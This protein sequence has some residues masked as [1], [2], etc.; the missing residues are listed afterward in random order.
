MESTWQGQPAS[1]VAS[2]PRPDIGPLRSHSHG[3]GARGPL[4]RW[5]GA[6]PA[7][8]VQ[9]TA[10]KPI[11]RD[12]KPLVPG[13]SIGRC[14]VASIVLLLALALGTTE[15]SAGETFSFVFDQS[16]YVAAP[17]GQVG[18]EVFLRQTGLAGGGQTNVLGGP[19]AVGMVGTGVLLTYPTGSSDAQVLST[20]DITGNIAFDNAGFGPY[21]AV[22]GGSALLS[23]AVIFGSPVFG[24]PVSS[25]T[26][27]FDLLLG[28]FTFTAGLQ[29]GQVTPVTASIPLV[30][31]SNDNIANTSPIPTVLSS[32]VSGEATITVAG[33]SVPEPSSLIQCFSAIAL[34]A[35]LGWRRRAALAGCIDREGSLFPS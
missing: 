4:P 7:G 34:L 29:L 10:A 8:S 32:I 30:P 16:N 6:D 24:T 20:S 5:A 26:D 14:L 25:L 28:T 17:G 27:T 13:L 33:S 31:D 11:H 23:Q 2:R 3:P 15:A 19:G 35:I 1:V 22:N 18:V 21:T 12:R 9:W